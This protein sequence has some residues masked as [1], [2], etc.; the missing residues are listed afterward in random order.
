MDEAYPNAEISETC[1]ND[2]WN[3]VYRVTQAQG[4]G[5]MWETTVGFTVVDP[6]TGRLKKRS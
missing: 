6:D 4:S 1:P 3:L 2:F 5:F